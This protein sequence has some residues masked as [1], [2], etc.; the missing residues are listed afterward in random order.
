MASGIIA[1][2]A[3]LYL[4]PHA[5]LI[6]QKPGIERQ[7]ALRN[8]MIARLLI[9]LVVPTYAAA[10]DRLRRRPHHVDLAPKTLFPLPLTH[11][12]P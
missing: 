12:F 4:V 7:L 10:M 1:K 3:R 11:L 2:I 8:D 5:D 9:R 6:C